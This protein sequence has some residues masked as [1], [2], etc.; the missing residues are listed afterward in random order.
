[1]QCNNIQNIQNDEKTFLIELVITIILQ[2]I[3][4]KYFFNMKQ[5]E[6]HD[7]ACD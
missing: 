7:F 1:M 2:Q 3:N 4:N 5:Q 6:M